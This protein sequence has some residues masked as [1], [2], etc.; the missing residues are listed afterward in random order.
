MR[1]LILIAA[2]TGSLHAEIDLIGNVDYVG[3]GDPRQTLDILVPKDHAE[4][5]QLLLVKRRNPSS[6]PP[7]KVCLGA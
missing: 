6:K 5:A 2:L 3:K 4:K 7:S 1:L